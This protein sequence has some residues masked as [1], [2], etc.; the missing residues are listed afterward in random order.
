MPLP[1]G[2]YEE[3]PVCEGAGVCATQTADTFDCPACGGE[4]LV[5]HGCDDAAD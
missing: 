1:D 2:T 4:G 5:P 3:C